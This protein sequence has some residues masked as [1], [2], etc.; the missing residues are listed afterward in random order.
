[1]SLN[2]FTVRHVEDL[3]DDDLRDRIQIYRDLRDRLRAGVQSVL[4][5]LEQ[6]EEALSALE[7]EE[8]RR[9]P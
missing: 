8:D 1:M 6:V 4:S 9:H 7:N 3:S 2:P 5:V